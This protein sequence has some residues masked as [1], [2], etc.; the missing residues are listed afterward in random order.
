MRGYEMTELQKAEKELFEL[1]HKVINLR[2]D[3]KPV[4]VKNYAFH[5]VE[6]KVTLLDLFGDKDTL[7]LIHNMGQ[8]CRYCTLWADGFNGF[9]QH[10]ESQFA[11]AMVSKD[12]PQ[13]QRQFA[14][15]RSWRFRMASHFGGDYIIEQ[16]VM[17]GENNMPGMVCYLKKGNEIYR[18]NSAVF[19]PGDSFCSQWNILSLA[20]IS[21]EEWTPQFSYWMRPEKMDDGGTNLN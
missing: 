21:T 13:V 8:G 1:T 17:Q 14:N 2:K 20:G 10:L 3:S 19:G 5:T 6:A 4:K 11:F 12:S 7:F 16:T 15:S 18:K 9:I